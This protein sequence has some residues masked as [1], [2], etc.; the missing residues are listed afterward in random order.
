MSNNIGWYARRL[1]QMSPVEMAGRGADAVRRMAWTRYQ[2]HPGADVG[3]PP[4]LLTDRTFPTPLPVGA[5]EQVSTVAAAGVIASADRILAGD[6][7][8]LGTR[9]PDIAEPDWFLDPVT[10][11]RAPQHTLAFRIDHRD[12]S[13]TGNVKAVWELSRHHHL[14]VLASA[15]WLTGNEA[16]AEVV[17]EQLRSW[18]AEN[19]FLSGVHW[20]SGIE[21]GVRLVSWVWVRR[22]LHDWPKVE[23]AL[24]QQPRGARPDL[25]APGVPRRVPQSRLLGQQPRGRRGVGA[26]RRRVRLPVVRGERCLA[27]R[28]DRPTGEGSCGPT[29]STAG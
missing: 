5:I 2:V 27:P 17:A 9:R 24:R 13:E 29:R 8:L 11:H 6:W 10:G 22:L 16:Y 4:G 15:W 12:E 23:R 18:W 3:P 25:V 19:P 28:R 14:T 7:S 1:R 21:L 20:T 26:A